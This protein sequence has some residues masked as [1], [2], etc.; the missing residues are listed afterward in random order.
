MTEHPNA[1]LARRGYAAFATGDLDTL[2]SLK[3]TV[4]GSVP[5]RPPGS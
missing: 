5:S 1:V 3:S 2:P 4:S